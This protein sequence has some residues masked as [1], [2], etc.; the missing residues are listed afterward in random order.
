MQLGSFYDFKTILVNAAYLQVCKGKFIS[1]RTFFRK[2]NIHFFDNFL[3]MSKEISIVVEIMSK[4]P[5]LLQKHYQ[6]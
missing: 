1:E 2:V 6:K 5:Q 4:K 3:G